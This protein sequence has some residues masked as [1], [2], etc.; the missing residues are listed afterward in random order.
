MINLGFL[1]REKL[2]PVLIIP[3]LRVPNWTVTYIINTM[4]H[5][6]DKWG[7]RGKAFLMNHVFN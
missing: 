7:E 4:P 1:L 5:Q 6:R 3:A 2:A